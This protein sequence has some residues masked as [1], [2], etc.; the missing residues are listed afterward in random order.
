MRNMKKKIVNNKDKPVPTSP[1]PEEKFGPRD[2]VL[3]TYRTKWFDLVNVP[4]IILRANRQSG[5]PFK[6]KLEEADGK[7]I[8]L[9]HDDDGGGAGSGQFMYCEEACLT[10]VTKYVPKRL[11]GEVKE[12]WKLGECFIPKFGFGLEQDDHDD[13]TGVTE[14]MVEKCGEQVMLV[15]AV[16]NRCGATWLLDGTE[17]YMW[18]APW[19]NSVAKDV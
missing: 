4:G 16:I 5:Y 19:I 11:G 17:N 6:I 1:L 2:R 15:A 13:R 3:V 8:N 14:T 10:L 12:V 7:P 9:G 18:L